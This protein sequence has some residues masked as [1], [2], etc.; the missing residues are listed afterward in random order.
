MKTVYRFYKK[1]D[2]ELMDEEYSD[3][4]I[5]DKYP[6]YAYTNSKEMR[7][8][9]LEV[10]NPDKFIEL[11]SKMSKE[12]YINF[13][14]G[15]SSQRLDIYK[16]SHCKGYEKDR[17]EP[18]LEDIEVISTWQEKEFVEAYSENGMFDGD[19]DYKFFP[20]L[21]KKKYYKA[22]EI[23]KFFDIWKLYSDANNYEH[24]MSEDEIDKYLSYGFPSISYD[25]LNVFI[26][27][28]GNT[29]F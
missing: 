28:H 22:L 10:R 13:A 27:L 24:F 6:L 5:E 20:F 14:N 1:P 3:L 29:M 15:H 7:N 26:M 17:S 18:I 9:F 11:K 25:E 4:S 23:L 12:D 19:I 21:F 8:G 16:Y 2:K